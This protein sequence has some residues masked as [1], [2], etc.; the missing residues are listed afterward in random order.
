[1]FKTPVVLAALGTGLLLVLIVIVEFRHYVIR[2]RE[3]RL[4]NLH[5]R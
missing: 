2:L 5:R 3:R 4:H 1:M